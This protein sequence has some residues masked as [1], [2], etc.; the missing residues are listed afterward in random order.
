[1]TT[2]MREN[3]VV[4]RSKCKNTVHLLLSSLLVIL[5]APVLTGYAQ[6]PLPDVE[7]EITDSAFVPTTNFCLEQLIR[8]KGKINCSEVDQLQPITWNWLQPTGLEQSQSVS[9]TTAIP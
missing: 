1:M 7:I 9:L 5:A 4:F 8:L 3:S 2:E 6:N